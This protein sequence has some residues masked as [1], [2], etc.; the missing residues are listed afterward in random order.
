M[1]GHASRERT[2][3]K[4][5]SG[6]LFATQPWAARSPSPDWYISTASSLRTAWEVPPFWPIDTGRRHFAERSTSHGRSEPPRIS[7]HC[8]LALGCRSRYW[9]EICRQYSADAALSDL[10]AQLPLLR[11]NRYRD[12]CSVCDRQSGCVVLLRPTLRPDRPPPRHFGGLRHRHC[13][14]IG[15]FAGPEHHLAISCPHSE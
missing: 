15:L 11:T 13:Q 5:G 1:A 3:R 8:H 6:S 7:Q 2:V 4:D 9:H 14:S 10:S 12:L